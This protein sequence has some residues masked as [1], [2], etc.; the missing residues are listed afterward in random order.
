MFGGEVLPKIDGI[1]LFFEVNPQ[2][3]TIIIQVYCLSSEIT[4]DVIDNQIKLAENILLA[5]ITPIGWDDWV[6]I[7]IN[8]VPMNRPQ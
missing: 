6:K 8:E 7:E 4:R 1:N 2:E 5:H 3:N